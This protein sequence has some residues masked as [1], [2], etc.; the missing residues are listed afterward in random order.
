MA[1]FYLNWAIFSPIPRGVGRPKSLLERSP[2]LSERLAHARIIRIDA[3]SGLSNFLQGGEDMRRNVHFIS[4]LLVGLTLGVWCS[5]AESK[6]WPKIITIG[7]APVGGT[8]YV[9]SGGFAKVLH[10]KMGLT[11]SV[12]ATGGPVHNTQLVN[13]KEA[14]F[15]GISAPAV[16]DGWHGLG[17]A[18]GK[19]HQ[20]IRIIF[21]MFNT[22][23]QI[24]ALKKTGVKE[25]QDLAGKSLGVGP[26]GGT[27]AMLWPKVL[28]TLQIKPS[29]VVNA[30]SSDLNSQL[31]DGL[32][33]ANAQTVGLPWS[34]ISEIETTHE[35][36]VFGL[37][38]KEMSKVI[39]QF[40]FLSMGNIPKGT[41]KT[42]KDKEI[43]TLTFWSFF[44]THKDMPEDFIYE[45][46][47]KVYE[48]TEIMIATH[49]SAKETRPE[50]IIY[51]PLP[52]HPGA[53]KFYKE[54]GIALPEKLISGN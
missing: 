40:P 18:K 48:N 13:A 25:V 31:K 54:K 50:H 7:G 9:Y 3:T 10:E 8:G 53:I 35:V 30:S 14:T 36:N 23:F 38:K 51:S 27:S 2:F 19:K 16:Y 34:L 49:K 5:L 43:E 32:L 46:V 47:K 11:A 6:D 15:G 21:P 4:I 52:L 41:Y 28:E 44:I 39:E 12:E 29:R 17:W 20:D 26:V 1:F 45:V 42:N 37:S 22:Y 24:Y 33:D